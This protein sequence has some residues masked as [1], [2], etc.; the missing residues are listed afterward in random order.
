MAHLAL[1]YVYTDTL[2]TSFL[3]DSGGAGGS[4]SAGDTVRAKVV[5]KQQCATQ[6]MR[7]VV[8]AVPL[9]YAFLA[10]VPVTRWIGQGGK[11]LFALLCNKKEA[12][13][14]ALGEGRG[15]SGGSGGS[16]GGG[17]GGNSITPVNE[18]ES[19]KEGEGRGRVKGGGVSGVRRGSFSL[20]TTHT[21]RRNKSTRSRYMDANQFPSLALCT[22]SASCLL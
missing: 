15:G 6:W 20:L 9:V 4:A 7:E 12:E 5:Q 22:S 13:T 3:H 1:I 18:S 16:G 10:S 11:A 2:V 17:G 8:A 19:K 21:S 14:G